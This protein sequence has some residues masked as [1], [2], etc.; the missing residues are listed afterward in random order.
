MAFK[1]F[2]PAII[3]KE[4]GEMFSM[5]EYGNYAICDFSKADIRKYARSKGIKASVREHPR[6]TTVIVR[7]TQLKEK[8]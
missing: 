4:L 8:L 6:D 7:L 3:D 5:L 2:N 1:I